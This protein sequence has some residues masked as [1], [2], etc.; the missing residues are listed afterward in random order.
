MKSYEE[1]VVIALSV[2]E[3]EEEEERIIGLFHN[4]VISRAM[5]MICI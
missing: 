2:E 4:I 5:S 1:L 3:D